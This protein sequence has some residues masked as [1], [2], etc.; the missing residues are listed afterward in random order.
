MDA[1]V[2]IGVGVGIGIGIY[3][4]E[5]ERALYV[6]VCLRVYMCGRCVRARIYVCLIAKEK[7]VRWIDKVWYIYTVFSSYPICNSLFHQSFSLS[8]LCSVPLR[9]VPL[10]Y[11]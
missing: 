8:L 9:Y 11:Y 1:G 6:R 10:R 2:G 7:K 3:Y 5:R 4:R